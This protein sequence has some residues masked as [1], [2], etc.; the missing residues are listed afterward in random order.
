[1]LVYLP[2]W[3]G[4]TVMA[5]PAIALLRHRLPR[6]IIM[7]LGR[8]GAA[9]LL[10]GMDE[11]LD[12]VIEAD[13]RSA[14]GPAKVAGR[15]RPMRIDAALILP[16]SFSSAMAV[17]LAG[18]AI[19]VGYDRDSRGLLL[20]HR[21]TPAKR[22]SPKWANPGAWEPVSAVDY[23][24][25]AAHT[26]L[27]ALD[28]PPPTEPGPPVKLEL[29]TTRGQEHLADDVLSLA[30]IGR[31]EPFALFN[32]G[33]NNPAKRWPVERFAAVAH[34]LITT[35]KMKVAIN[36]APSEK[37]LCALIAQAITLNHPEDESM[38]SC[39]PELG[40]TIGSLKA[41][42][43][44]ARLM[45]T[46]DT[47]PRHVAAAFG[48]PCVTLFGPTDP[49]WTTLPESFTKPGVPREVILVSDPTLPASE[50]ADDHPERCR[51]ENITTQSVIDAVERVL[52]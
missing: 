5:T 32:P 46:N 50:V 18:I 37:E 8:T 20:T 47:G 13:G 10:A 51:I 29:G 24:L 25:A 12:E 17:R 36:G 26:L 4:D 43:R 28:L 27:D 1:M 6:S 38:V 19:R 7:G 14:V 11:L 2:S 49:R 21:L 52:R 30:K 48:T 23:Y 44:R 39:L 16:N 33:G 35:R 41:I 9:E 31:D 45:I 34:H 3:V 15:L 42:T 40:G 22:T